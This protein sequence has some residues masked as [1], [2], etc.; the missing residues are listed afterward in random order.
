MDIALWI[1]A[2]LMAL[3]FLA[4]GASKL[5]TPKDQLHGKGMT[6]VEDFS[7]SQIKIIGAI[8]VLGAVGLILP[9][10]F[11]DLAIL[12]LLAATGLTVTMI[13]AVIVHVRRKEPF[14]PA[15]VLGVLVAF[16]AVGRFFVAP[17]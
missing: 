5:M 11:D 13:G 1:V 8:E 16:V 6:Y 14:I 17:F 4:A 10:F 9:A 7:A 2:G 12:V 3:V 15:L